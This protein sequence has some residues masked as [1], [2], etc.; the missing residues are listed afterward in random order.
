VG[1]SSTARQQSVAIYIM[2][3]RSG[4]MDNA[5]GTTTKWKAVTSALSTFLGQPLDGTSVGL[6]YFPIGGTSTSASGTSCNA[7]DYA[8]PE[9]EIDAIAQTASKITASMAG[10][11]TLSGT[12]TSAAL[13]GAIDHSRA[14][15][16]ARSGGD[17]TA[18]VVLATDGEPTACDLSLDHI[19]A[20]AASG[21]SGAPSIRTFVI[22]VG[23][24]LTNLNGIAKAGGTTSAFLVDTTSG[25]SD[26]F[27][28][29][30]NDI[31]GSA[32]RCAYTIPAPPSGQTLD[33]T[34]VNVEYKPGGGGA[35]VTFGQAADAAACGTKANAWHYDSA[36]SPTAIHLCPATCTAVEADKAA[37]VN[38]VLGCTTRRGEF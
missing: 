24:S 2:L 5:A 4:S 7:A 11:T 16:Q 13:Q 3:D 9:V 6:Q 23:R 30:L 10:Q 29:A 36:T 33:P 1:T 19:D 28:K 26:A 15:L 17:Y 38:I 27:L 8:S 25:A 18:V 34:Q 12:P 37:T 21:L 22:G 14:W 32:V 31:R 35:A 20:I